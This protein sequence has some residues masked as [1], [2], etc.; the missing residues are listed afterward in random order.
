MS[1]IAP[2]I[3]GHKGATVV[4]VPFDP[5]QFW[6]LK[7]LRLAGRRHGWPVEGRAGNAPFV[8]YI[9]ERWG[10]LFVPIDAD[11]LKVE[12]GDTL[13]MMLKPTRDA[14]AIAAAIALSKSTTQ[15]RKARQDAEVPLAPAAGRRASKRRARQR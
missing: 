14:T 2:L 1:F 7:P 4:P 5:E 6:G 3:E 15:P 8:S 13:S 9:G 12:V 11:A 10:R